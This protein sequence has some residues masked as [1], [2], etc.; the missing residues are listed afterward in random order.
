MNKNEINILKL[1]RHKDVYICGYSVACNLNGN[2]NEIIL[3]FNSLENNFKFD[4]IR[5]I[6]DCVGVITTD[7]DYPQV[8]LE[9]FSE[10]S[11]VLSFSF[12][13]FG[14]IFAGE[15]LLTIVAFLIPVL[16]S[17]PFV[18]LEVFVGFVQA[19]VFTMLTSVFYSL[20]I[21]SHH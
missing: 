11:K 12:R 14:N 3:M 6:F 9:I 1:K 19:L 5:G 7:K 21:F 13:L 20:A 17:F 15:V 2:D 4:Y 16:A 18:M 10:I 8:I